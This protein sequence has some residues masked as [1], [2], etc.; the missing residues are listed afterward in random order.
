MLGILLSKMKNMNAIQLAWDFKCKSYPDRLIKKFKDQFCV[1]GDHQVE[2]ITHF[3]D[4][5][6]GGSMDNG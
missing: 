2:G 3:E 6:T 4:V 1:K 5:C